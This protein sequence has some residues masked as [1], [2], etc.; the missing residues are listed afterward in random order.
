MSVKITAAE[1]DLENSNRQR[2]RVA[3]KTFICRVSLK[4]P[5]WSSYQPLTAD[6]SEPEDPPVS[7]SGSSDFLLNTQ[8][9]HFTFTSAH[10]AK[11]LLPPS[12]CWLLRG[13]L[14]LLLEET[15][16][17]LHI[18]HIYKFNFLDLKTS[19]G[20]S[21]S[22]KGSIYHVSAAKNAFHEGLKLNLKPR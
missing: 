6:S 16:F 22:V 15:S 21:T 1:T 4:K 5:C 8:V 9:I 2:G 10:P 11:R 14:L 3:W 17:N 7:K 12:P 20:T 18:I 13:G 19:H